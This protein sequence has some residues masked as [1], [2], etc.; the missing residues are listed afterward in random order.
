M[1]KI[2]HAGYTGV[3]C[4]FRCW[5]ASFMCR[6][7]STVMLHPPATPTLPSIDQ[8]RPA[9]RSRH[10]VLFFSHRGVNTKCRFCANHQE[11]VHLSNFIP[12]ML[13]KA[14][15]GSIKIFWVWRENEDGSSHKAALYLGRP[16]L[17]IRHL[18]YSWEAFLVVYLKRSF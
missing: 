11:S 17:R 16:F 3:C 1:A 5:W 4:V 15:Q 9:W 18:G 8:H 12:I 13:H 6:S 14:I 7:S 10:N 2:M